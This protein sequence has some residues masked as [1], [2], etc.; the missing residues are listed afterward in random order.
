MM[1]V[2]CVAPIMALILVQFDEVGRGWFT[3]VFGMLGLTP[4][5]MRM[6]NYYTLEVAD[7]VDHPRYLSTMSIAMAIPPILFSSLFGAMVDWISFEFVFGLVTCFV[8]IGW[9]LTLFLEEPR[10]HD[11]ADS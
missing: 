9:V 5:T 4:V 7:R 6:F 3:L 2:M 10:H 8:L 11:R 1:L